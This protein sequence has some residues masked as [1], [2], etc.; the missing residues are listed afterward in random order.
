MAIRLEGGFETSEFW[1]KVRESG[2][3]LLKDADLNH[4]NVSI[5]PLTAS[6]RERADVM[7]RGDDGIA[8]SVNM[9]RKELKLAIPHGRFEQT[10]EPHHFADMLIVE[11]LMTLEEGDLEDIDRH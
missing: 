9:E 3:G 7:E 10:E 6:I 4:W 5:Q 2:T 1:Q 11:T 8:Q